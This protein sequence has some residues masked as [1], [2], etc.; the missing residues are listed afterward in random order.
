MTCSGAFATLWLCCAAVLLGAC[1]DEAVTPDPASLTREA[2]GHYCNMIVADHPGPKAQVFEKGKAE[3]L[4]FSS[5]RDG[6][7][8]LSLPGE[9]Q[10]PVAIYVH[11]MGRVRNWNK[12]PNHGIWMNARDAI[13]VIGSSRRGG[14]GAREAVPFKES[15]KATSFAAEFGGRVVAFEKIPIDYLVGDSNEH[16]P[17]AAAGQDHQN[18]KSHH[19]HK[20]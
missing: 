15:D 3:P 11:D 6:L 14:M 10:Q 8:Y 16:T 1:S 13:Y 17:P 2:I 9:A 12:P 5:V 7:A 19:G 18:H 20:G 4:W